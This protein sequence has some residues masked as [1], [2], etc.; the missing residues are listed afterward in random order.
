MLLQEES[1]RCKLLQS[2]RPLPL[3]RGLHLLLCIVPLVRESVSSCSV[4][5]GA[6]S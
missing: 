3:F 2:F 5:P 1:L 6:F 4:L